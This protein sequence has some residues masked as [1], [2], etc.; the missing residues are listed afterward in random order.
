MSP[1]AE[2]DVLLNGLAD[3]QLDEAALARLEA[4]LG[5]DAGARRRYRRFAALDVGLRWD[6]AAA[7]RAA[8]P[9]PV[10]RSRW[11]PLAAAAAA[12]LLLT[13]G[14]LLWSAGGAVPALIVV[15]VAGGSLTWSDGTGARR[16]LAGGEG[17]SSG[18]LAL[19]GA[20]ASAR[21]RFADGSTVVLAG[22][23]VIALAGSAQKLLHLT[24]GALSADVQPQ[25]AGRPMLVRTGTAELRVIGTRFTVT[26]DA[27]RTTLEVEHGRVR[28]ERLADGQAVEVA[29]Q[30]SAVAGL[31]PAQPLVAA[32]R[33]PTPPR[34]SLDLAHLDA[35]R[36]TG[37]WVA[38]GAASPAYVRAA[39]YLAARTPQG[40]PI[41]HYGVRIS[42]P[43]EDGRP[44]VRFVAG[45]SLT[46]RYRVAR[47]TGRTHFEV[48]VCTHTTAGAFGG[49]FSA[50]VDTAGSTPDAD[51]WRT[52]VL[53]VAEFRPMR[54]SQPTMVGCEAVFILPR[55]TWAAAGLEVAAV[56]VAEP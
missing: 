24:H 10:A 19:D 48:L 2:L 25:P 16:D 6:Y 21:L 22:D 43:D 40:A 47:R 35:A 33:A 26:T 27:E 38:P 37:T 50:G 53:G 1:T 3:D 7:A 41:V 49:T 54:A 8:Q 30:Q 12:L 55:A 42:A 34:W 11:R 36:W 20:S 29:A 32:A 9:V 17:L 45:S 13:C 28:L 14:A 44:F 5:A 18:Q 15:D 4:L 31:D 39:P 46:L 56:E 51:G 23:S 52:A